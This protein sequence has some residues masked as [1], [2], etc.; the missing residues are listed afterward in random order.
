MGR[1]LPP[2]LAGFRQLEEIR[3]RYIISALQAADG[4]VTAVAHVLGIERS[5]LYRIMKEYRVDRL[6]RP[7]PAEVAA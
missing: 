6:G 5:T 4:N 3:V 1:K 7:L 2:R